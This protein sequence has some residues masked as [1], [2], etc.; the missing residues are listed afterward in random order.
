MRKAL[1]VIM[2]GMVLV[3]DIYGIINEIIAK[4]EEN[5]AKN[6]VGIVV[7]VE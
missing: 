4:I 5:N 3:M 7:Y 2:V 1:L 6:D